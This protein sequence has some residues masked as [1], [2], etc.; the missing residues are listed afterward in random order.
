MEQ[1]SFVQDVAFEDHGAVM[2]IESAKRDRT[3]ERE[4]N[5]TEII[6]P[7]GQIESFQLL[8]PMLTRLY[9]DQRWLAWVDPP[10]ALV[11]KWQ[12]LHEIQT[13]HILVLHSSDDF[14]AMTL[15]SLALSAGTCHAV[16]LWHD[17]RLSRNAFRLL[18]EAS[19]QGDSHGVVLSQRIS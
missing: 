8:L 4:G 6:L 17:G 15:A 5:V 7:P 13:G 3:Q 18:E 12:Q 9:Q 14:S 19:A 10:K 16:V 1:L 11:S 2:P